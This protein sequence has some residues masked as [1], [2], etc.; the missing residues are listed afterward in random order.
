MQRR[1]DKINIPIELL[2]SFITIQEQGSFTKAACALHLTQPAISAQIKRLQQLVGGEVFSRDGLGI[3]LS[4]KGA[5]IN[6]YA[7]RILDLNDQVL[8]L[9][10]ARSR[11][12]HLRI[13]ISSMYAER[14][15][16]DIVKLCG[17]IEEIERVQF[18]SE[19][20]GDLAKS[21]EAGYLDAAFIV[22]VPQPHARL[23]A[24]WNEKLAW[25][26]APDFLL[27]PGA[28]I[29]VLSRPHSGSDQVMF[30][31]L[32]RHGMQFSV[33]F[34]AED[35]SAQLAALR[36]GLGFFVMPERM[37]MPDLKIAREYYLPPLPDLTAGFYGNEDL[38]VRRVAPLIARLDEVMTG[39]VPCVNP[40][41][42][43]N[44]GQAEK[45]VQ[46]S[47]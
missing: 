4:E 8:S 39:A 44:A 1:H 38:D 5:A 21:L 23:L 28:P 41:A 20:C 12:R 34:V 33:A 32:E 13:G 46:R 45:S 30:E 43:R 17:N 10:G 26:C 42:R 18:C 29:P 36:A 40:A 6:K 25:V 19:T 35:F 7:R 15:L 31:V 2:R 22:A 14:I 24:T 37:V 9:A 47:R 16:H 3:T 11:T 27:S